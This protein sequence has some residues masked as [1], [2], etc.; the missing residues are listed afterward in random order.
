MTT[1]RT[2]SIITFVPPRRG[3][4]IERN[5]DVKV[6]HEEIQQMKLKYDVQGMT[7]SACSAAVEREVGKL[8]GVSSVSVNLLANNMVVEYDE[9]VLTDS[10]IEQAVRS[11]GYAAVPAGA[12][13]AATEK[14]SDNKQDAVRNI[15]ADAE[16]KMKLRLIISFAFLIP[17]MYISMGHM[18]KFPLPA[19]IHGTGNEV[20][21]AL[22]QLLL[23][24]PITAVNFSFFRN[25]FRA[26][27]RRH[28]NMD[29]LIAVGSSAALI[30]GVFAIYRI[31]YGL[32][33]GMHELVMQYSM[34]LYFESAATI[35]TL[36][37]L[38]KFLETRS[39]GKTSEAIARLIDLAP[40]KAVVLRD[41]NEVEIPAEDVRIGDIVVVRPGSSIP[42]DGVI[43]QGQTAVD[44]SALTGESMPVDKQVGDSVAAATINQ[45]GYIRI[46]AVKVGEDTALSQIIRL[47]E[48]AG[49]TKAPI[50][51]LADKISGVFVPVVIAI[52]LVSMIVWLATGQSF[53][54]ALS[55]AIAVLVISCPCALGLAT[56]VAIMVGTGVGARNGM[57]FKSAEVLE[58]LHSIDTVVLDK[59]GTI[60]EGKPQVTDIITASSMTENV[61]LSAAA[62]IEQPSE[63]PLAKAIIAHAAEKNLK[64][65]DVTNYEALSGRGLRAVLSGKTWL[66]GN[67]ALM[68]EN[69]IDTSEWEQK[70]DILAEQGKT[71]LIFAS[72][73][74]IVG[75]I[76]V[77][78]VIKSGSKEAVKKM[79]SMGL[80]VIMLTGDNV[81][82]AEA[83]GHEVEVNSVRAEVMP[84]DKDQVIQILQQQGRRVA[85]VGDGINDA[86]AL[87]RA[88][89]GLAI[90]AGTDIAIEAADLVLMRSDLKDAVTAIRLSHRTIRNIKQN[91]FWAFF[92]NVVG[93]PLAAGLF[94]PF[95]G[96]QLS[97]MFAAAAMS[98][99]SVCVVLNALRLRRFN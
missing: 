25:G 26:L 21:F 61:F 68:Q 74:Q 55:I 78:D 19:W 4:G 73:Q 86:P 91:L 31:G 6:R 23:T 39:K 96:W 83:I 80:E 8:E 30:Y 7:C 98:L 85:M 43:V 5:V 2:A 33:H 36:I 59:T 32:G 64:L 28:P 49:S 1:D 95:T 22:T 54:F 50:A 48:E 87:V 77:A 40:Q 92:Y 52:A 11:A 63:H 20:S 93:I 18:F 57:L 88:D 94:I 90:G 97:P 72:E 45:T 53:E 79:Q 56:P 69:S 65:E 89:A 51:R 17:L 37:T 76:A 16:Q 12:A 13:S 67:A 66:A 3:R 46:E 47:V 82:T 15:H 42:V 84:A 75:I 38:G 14:R 58:I 60:T 99:S 35:L 10:K 71:P 62:A 9:A 44:M 81:R 24:I 41:G 29:S 70:A 34:D 27:W